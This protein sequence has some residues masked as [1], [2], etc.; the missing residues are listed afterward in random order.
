MLIYR[1][2][3]PLRRNQ[4]GQKPTPAYP[5]ITQNEDRELDITVQRLNQYVPF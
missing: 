4:L 1:A 3:N 2:R 5:V